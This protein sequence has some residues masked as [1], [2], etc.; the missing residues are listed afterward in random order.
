MN[1]HEAIVAWNVKGKPAKRRGPLQTPWPA[2]GAVQSAIRADASLKAA[3]DAE[4]G[5][6]SAPGPQ[7]HLI[8]P[9]RSGCV[10]SQERHR[11]LT[12]MLAAQEK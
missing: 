11:M 8:D 10:I 1:L 6:L 3:I 7:R 2:R 12:E 9:Q 4:L 5:R